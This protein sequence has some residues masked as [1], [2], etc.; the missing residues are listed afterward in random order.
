[1][2]YQCVFISL[3]AVIAS[4]YNINVCRAVMGMLTVG[5]MMSTVTK[6]KVDV[7]DTVGKVI[8]TQFKQVLEDS[9]FLY[10]RCSVSVP[11][12][13]YYGSL[14]LSIMKGMRKLRYNTAL[15]FIVYYWRRLLSGSGLRTWRST[16]PYGFSY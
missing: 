12:Y 13:S 3:A 14:P 16:L 2:Y 9:F 11:L 1:M 10:S 8:Y 6:G 5:N 4:S 15:Q 7:S